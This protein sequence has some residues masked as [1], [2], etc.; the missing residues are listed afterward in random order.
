MTNTTL[1]AHVV[2]LMT[3]LTSLGCEQIDSPIDQEVV[4]VPAKL[5]KQPGPYS[6]AM[7]Q[8]APNGPYNLAVHS[9]VK[10]CASCHTQHHEQWRESTHGLSSFNNPFYQVAFDSYVEQVGLDKG[11]FCGGCHDPTLV[12][13]GAIAEPIKPEHASNYLGI[14]C[15]SCHGISAATTDGVASYTLDTSPIPI[16]NETDPASL[17]AHIRRVSKPILKEDTLCIS[18]H[19]GFL[20]QASGHKA[21]LPA[22]DEFGPWRRSGFANT[23][24]A[25][26]IVTPRVKQGCKDCHMPESMNEGVAHSHRFPGGHTTLAYA[27]GSGKQLDAV[28]KIM[29]NRIAFDIPAWREGSQSW[30]AT[31]SA[32]TPKTSSIQFDVVISNTNIGHHFPAGARD[33]RN[34]WVELTLLDSAGKT[35]G[36]SGHQYTQS[37]EEEDVHV[38]QVGL[39]DEN[40]DLVKKHGVGHFR[41]PLFD[42]TVAPSDSRAARYLFQPT[43][44]IA[45]PLQI[46][47]R[48]LQKR[49]SKTFLDEACKSSKTQRG[50]DFQK[51]SLTHHSVP[52]DA[53]KPQPT[54]VMATSTSWVGKVSQSD[55]PAWLRWYRHGIALRHDLQERLNVAAQSLQNALSQL[56]ANIQGHRRA[57][58]H[59]SLADIFVQQSKLAEAN[60]HLDIAEKI[61]PNQPV[62]AKLRGQGLRKIW[63]LKE[64]VPHFRKA[65]ALAPN[66]E[67]RWRDLA[68]A[69]GS[70]GQHNQAFKA[71]QKGLDVES[72][73]A[74]LLR[75]QMLAIEKSGQ[76]HS[77][78]ARQS[79]LDFKHDEA[80]AKLKAR[81]SQQS[82]ECRKARL[83]LRI[84]RIKSEI[85]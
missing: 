48:L 79:F 6:P 43:T 58:I 31:N 42:Q 38:L 57:M 32:Q 22:L 28:K 64:A 62:I 60:Q 7:A 82:A 39:V 3:C 20:S 11:A 17:H 77:K 10:L 78:E 46:Q 13:T 15:N 45:W 1:R 73:D 69:L 61:T 25:S 30:V 76:P 9:E 5:P 70:T 65:A 19:K 36:N 44:Q 23:S 56:P 47:A 72:R 14:T 63:K 4:N 29:A 80:A 12:F 34:V 18:C 27:S 67:A 83:P 37:G 21:F 51:N 75:L 55:T 52:I 35:V 33:L 54:V 49:F 40:G 81:C 59:A 41:T 24:T 68:A 16:P 66:D 71:A 26:R 2:M 50:K 84:Y 74:H 85:N 53:C 8:I